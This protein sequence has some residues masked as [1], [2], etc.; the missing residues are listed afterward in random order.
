MT[1]Q[2]SPVSNRFHIG[3]FKEFDVDLEYNDRFAIVHFAR[4]DK[5]SKG[6]I[7]DIYFYFKELKEFV[8]SLGFDELYGAVPINNTLMNRLCLN[9]I[10]M[11]FIREW[12]GH[13]VY[14]VGD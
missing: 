14:K 13:Y 8:Q 3:R 7:D 10:G 2:H 12:E 4:L 6:I 1:T 11:E 9:H 5:L